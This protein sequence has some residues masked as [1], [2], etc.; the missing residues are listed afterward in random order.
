MAF[1]RK[2]LYDEQ[3][4]QLSRS[5][6]DGKGPM[7]QADDYA[8]LIKGRTARDVGRPATPDSAPLQA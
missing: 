8:F 3:S 5:W 1:I 6:R 7:G 4:G 2:E